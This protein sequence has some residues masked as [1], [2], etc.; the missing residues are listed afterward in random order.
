MKTENLKILP[1]SITLSSPD[2]LDLT[3]RFLSTEKMMTAGKT[4]KKK[5]CSKLNH[6]HFLRSDDQTI[7]ELYWGFAENHN[8]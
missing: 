8:K 2:F 6:I 1:E 7:K 5:R 4:N 3:V